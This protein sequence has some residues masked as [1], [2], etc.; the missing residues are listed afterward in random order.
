MKRENRTGTIRTIRRN[1]TI[2]YQALS[3]INEHGKRISLGVYSSKQEAMDVLQGHLS[4]QCFSCMT[5]IEVYNEWSK[6][7]IVSRNDK[8]AFSYCCPLYYRRF[9]SITEHQLLHCIQRG[10]RIDSNG[11][12]KY[13]TPSIRGKIK[14]LCN[15]L[16][17]YALLK[18]YVT[19]NLSRNLR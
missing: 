15:R 12:K 10:Y 9:S 2:R 13:A 4:N 7:R 18:N 19:K 1:N 5:F 14:S 6:D 3:P 16:Y 17:D 8:S 11:N